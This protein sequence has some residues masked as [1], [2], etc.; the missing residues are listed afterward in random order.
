M[1]IKRASGLAKVN[2]SEKWVFTPA[3]TETVTNLMN[4]LKMSVKIYNYE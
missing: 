1:N 3:E 4:K 2:T